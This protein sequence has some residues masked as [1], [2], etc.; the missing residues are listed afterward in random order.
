[1]RIAQLSEH[2]SYVRQAT[3]EGCSTGAPASIDQASR[4][5]CACDH[6]SGVAEDV[7]SP[8]GNWVG[9]RPSHTCSGI[10]PPPFPA[11]AIDFR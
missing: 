4:T 10:M 1:M 8:A 11:S 3:I 7:P 9:G 2:G 6:A 5:S